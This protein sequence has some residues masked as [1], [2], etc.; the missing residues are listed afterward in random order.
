MSLVETFEPLFRPA[1]IAVVGASATAQAIGNRF[2]RHLREFGYGGRI[3][4]IHPTAPQIEGL[5]ACPT[6]ADVPGVVDYAYIAVAARH[7]PG[8]LRN[9]PGKVR[10]AQ[11]ISSGF[12]ET[13]DGAALESQ[14][15][16][17]A[18]AAGT[19]LIGPNCLGVHSPA[20]RVTFTDKA[21][22][23]P[24]SVGIVCQSGGLGIDIIRRGQNRGLRYSGLVTIGNAADLGAVEL[25]EYFLEDPQTRVIGMYLESTREGRC[26]FEV[27]RKA[28]AR[29]PVVLL[30]GGRTGQ[31]L[32]AA[33]SHT[34]AL[35]GSQRAWDALGRQTGM[36]LVD[37]LDDFLDALLA[38]QCLTPRATATTRAVL[39]GNGGGTSVLAAD[40]F[41]RAGIAVPAF[42]EAT[43]RTMEALQLPAGSSVANPIDVPAGALHQDE[44]RVAERILAAVAASGIADALVI[45]V[46]MA[47]LLGYRHVDMLGNI[48]RAALRLR[49]GQ[50]SGMHVALVLRS[51]GDPDTEERKRAY[52]RSAIASGVPVFDEL[53]QAARALAAVRVV[54]AF[55]ERQ[56]TR[57]QPET[58]C[59]P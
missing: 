41:D 19:R 51:D 22:P 28:A 21:L 38:L 18:R 3:V 9:P 45:H 26:L 56:Q 29:K 43:L 30:K 6:L 35:A 53:A 12:G 25:L 48:I 16:M 8:V 59:I 27:L 10:F 58:T 24:G 52:R 40:A 1:T 39:F 36:P 34:G 13:A 44:G 37:T 11:V 7:A 31:G 54:E 55:R 49:E 50:S 46:N 57:Q 4:P 17:A 5:P 20:G 33:A 15:V 42:D 2:I 23:E 47:V 14:L 32:R